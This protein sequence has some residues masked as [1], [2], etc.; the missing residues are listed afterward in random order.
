MIRINFEN[1]EVICDLF[2]IKY[3][4]IFWRLLATISNKDLIIRITWRLLNERLN[5]YKFEFI[6]EVFNMQVIWLFIWKF[7]LNSYYKVITRNFLNTYILEVLKTFIF[8]WF[9]GSNFLLTCRVIVILLT[10]DFVLLLIVFAW[11]CILRL[12]GLNFS[13][14]QL[15]S[16]VILCRLC[17][18]K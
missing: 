1:G 3:K 15:S 13:W 2:W 7:S 4:V 10:T 5:E 9:S 18:T 14:S 16:L 11:K 17:Y 6:F 12:I 8:L